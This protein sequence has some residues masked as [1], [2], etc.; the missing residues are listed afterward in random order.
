VER[1]HLL[2][3]TLS[4]GVIMVWMLWQGETRGPPGPTAPLSSQAEAPVD[5]EATPSLQEPELAPLPGLADAGATAPDT[6]EGLEA[7]ERIEIEMPQYQAVLTSRGA[8]ISKW[9]L[10]SYEEGPRDARVP[11]VLTP[12]AP[13]FA[14]VVTTSFSEFDRGNLAQVEWDVVE[15]GDAA[16]TFRVTRKGVTVTKA[17]RFHPDSYAF[18]LE[19]RVDNQSDGAVAPRFAVDWPAAVREGPDFREQGL[20]ALH[21]GSLESEFLSGGP[22]SCS[23][24]GGRTVED[25]PREVDFAGVQTTYFLSALLPDEPTEA[26]ARFEILTGTAGVTRVYFDPVALEPGQSATRTFRG[27]MGPK[28]VAELEALGGSAV[29]S[30]DVGWSW[31]APMTRFFGWMLRALYSI[32]PNYGV[33]IIILTILVRVVTLPLVTKQMRSMEGMRGLQPK[34]K[35]LQE[36]HK[37]DKQKQSEA[38]MSLYRSEGVNPLGGCLP[39][40]L[41]LPVMIGLFY[42]LRSSIELREAPFFGWITD[43]SAPE[44][45]FMIPG[46]ELPVRVLPLIMGATMVLQQRMTPQPTMDPAQAR[47]MTT[48][49]PIVMLVVFYQFASGL[50]LYWM[51][52]NVLAIAHQLWI[53]RGNEARSAARGPDKPGGG[54]SVQNKAAAAAAAAQRAERN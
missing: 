25:Y 35:E 50:V 19:V 23:G 48:V 1:N 22:M 43:L 26:S 5:S 24:S 3:F 16:V 39:M 10:K 15:R 6:L 37:D 7:R 28:E 20:V 51:L 11:V 27:Y 44:T 54:K 13:P 18:D 45:L 4:I 41:Q 29:E 33:A 12:G 2:A 9:S 40:V 8:G 52:S 14:T 42:A 46:L 38:M 31:I 49:M 34:I 30:I 47:M 21:Q 32:I 36:K 53:R 17:Y